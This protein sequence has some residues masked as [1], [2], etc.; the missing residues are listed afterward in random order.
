MR[1]RF[2]IIFLVLVAISGNAT[3]QQRSV[4]TI[5]ADIKKQEAKIKKSTDLLASYRNKSRAS[6]RQL[7][8][9]SARIKERGEMVALYGEQIVA[10]ERRI[11]NNTDSLTLLSKELEK[12]KREYGI[13][14]RRAYANR[15]IN[16]DLTLIFASRNFNDAV[17]RNE[18]LERVNR[19]R[20]QKAE[21]IRTTSA[22]IEH[23][24]EQ[25]LAQ[26]KQLAEKRTERE[27]ERVKMVTDEREGKQLLDKLNKQLS[28]AQSSVSTQQQQLRKLQK[29]REDAVKRAVKT[30]QKAT[31]S[32]TAAQRQISSELAKRFEDNKGKLP[33]P[34][35]GTLIRD[36]GANYRS[37]SKDNNQGFI[38]AC[39]RGAAV[40]SV[41]EGVVISILHLSDG[42]LSVTISHGN[43][44]TAYTG[45][46]SVSVKVNESVKTQQTIGTASVSN[47]SD[48]WQI[49]FYLFGSS[50]DQPINPKDWLAQGA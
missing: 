1:R 35:S 19:L 20:Q 22:L 2:W 4:T 21:H 46:S 25:L 40:V 48:D 41:F 47:N 30:A 14:I 10:L 42:L 45:L 50:S 23:N 5:D 39:E 8:L 44:Y 6:E 27:Q 16:S 36:F 32:Q 28:S 33:A 43:Y 24:N 15:L 31:S 12:L 49:C 17:R 13:L 18:L 7:A 3:A 38:Y 37:N 9:L 26:R 34:V 29:E 11:N